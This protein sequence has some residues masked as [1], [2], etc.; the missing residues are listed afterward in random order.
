MKLLVVSNMYPSKSAPGYGT[1]VKNFCDQAKAL[2]CD[3]QLAVMQK[4]SGKLGKLTA[5]VGFYLKSFLTCLFGNQDIVYVHYASHSSPGVLLAR[6]FRKFT[7]YT[8]C[9]GSDVIPQNASQ[10]KMQKNTRAILQLSRKVIVPSDFFR[11]T[12]AE[13]YGIDNSRLFVCPSGGVDPQVFYPAPAQKEPFTIGFVSRLIEGKGA[14]V[15]LKACEQLSDRNFRILMVGG[16]PQEAK[17]RALAEQ[18]QLSDRLELAGEQPQAALPGYLNQMDVFVFPT[19][20]AESLGLVAVEA[21]ACGVC[22]VASDYAAPADY[23]VDG[24]NGYKFPADDYNALAQT[25]EKVR[26]LPED[27]KE[28]LKKGALETAA[29]FNREAVTQSLKTVLEE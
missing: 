26:A 6:K 11:R 27:T 28:A 13:K 3:V 25:L 2:G 19:T 21:M 8:N 14:D 10:E 12:V 4:K 16:G 24:V 22:V 5:Y 9:H 7:I 20:L 29:G 1:F 17:I 15:L 18:L 23:V